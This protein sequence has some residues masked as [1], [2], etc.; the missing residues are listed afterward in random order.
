MILV[1]LGDGSRATADFDDVEAFSEW[2]QGDIRQKFMWVQRYATMVVHEPMSEAEVSR[3][4]LR[5]G[6]PRYVM[7]ERLVKSSRQFVNVLTIQSI[8]PLTPSEQSYYE[9]VE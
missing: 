8:E 9:A 5:G 3:W 4:R 6:A 2:Q 7:H 1:I